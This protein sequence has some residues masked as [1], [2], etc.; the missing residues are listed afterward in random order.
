MDFRGHARGLPHTFCLVPFLQLKALTPCVCVP[1]RRSH[2][3]RKSASWLR[4][5]CGVTLRDPHWNICN[6]IFQNCSCSSKLELTSWDTL[7]VLKPLLM[8]WPSL[9]I[10]SH[11]SFLPAI[12]SP[13]RVPCRDGLLP[14]IFRSGSSC[15]MGVMIPSLQAYC[16]SEIK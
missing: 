13:E 10:I 1:S 2:G 5:F 15:G 9:P 7:D 14:A 11:F 8:D 16:E 3:L 4:G 12:P 6:E